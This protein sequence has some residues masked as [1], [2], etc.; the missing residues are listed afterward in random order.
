M[1]LTPEQE[2]EIERDVEEII[3]RRPLPKPKVVAR[4]DLGPIRDA[5]VHVSRADPN[6]GG[7]ARVVQVRRPEWCTINLEA[8][9]QQQRV[10]ERAFDDTEQARIDELNQWGKL[11]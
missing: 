2:A 4:N 7:E 1:A 3:G 8:Y 6:S 5:D 11:Y 9:E 10:R